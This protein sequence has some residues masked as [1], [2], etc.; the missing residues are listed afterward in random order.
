MRSN[1]SKV[2]YLDGIRG[3][4]ALVVLIHHFTLA[5]LPATYT[6]HT[7]DAHWRPGWEIAYGRSV[8]SVFSDGNFAVCVFFV[9]SGYVLSRQYFLSA[10]V[11]TI[12]SAA[13]R[14]FLRLYVPVAAT[15]IIAYCFLKLGWYFNVEA[16]R[17]AHSEWWMG[18]FWVTDKP[19]AK[20]LSGLSYSTMF[21]GDGFLDTSLWT[22]STELYGSMLVFAFLVL[23]HNT[24][25]RAVALLALLA[26][27]ICFELYYYAA[28]LLGIA[29]HFTKHW[30]LRSA[31][32]R[33][34]LSTL[35]FVLS[36]TLGAFPAGIGSMLHYDWKQPHL[37][38]AYHVLGS[39]G[40]IISVLM[41][42][43]LQRFFGS[44]PARFLG[45]ISFC[46]Y[47]LH[48]LVLGSA[49]C[50]LFL[51]LWRQIGYMRAVGVAFVA[52]VAITIPAAYVMTRLVDDKGVQ[53]SR[54]VY[55][56]WFRKEQ[57]ASAES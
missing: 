26:Y 44:R 33:F 2:F 55:R 45:D 51:K 47:L 16:S 57:T 14:R 32:W 35:L 49:S 50:F 13:S 29:L 34:V 46:L 4:A 5:F 28:F 53:L 48:A 56:R 41:S 37:V 19:E 42:P 9:L 31:P 11:E 3:I 40:L 21:S 24:R 1:T 18:K 54:Y 7:D 25:N 15:L 43:R 10:N 6:L 22:I 12:V 27:F 30:E 8:F 39:V 38:V 23:T 17:V 20:L 52:T 36:M